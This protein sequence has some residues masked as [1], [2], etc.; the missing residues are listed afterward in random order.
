M[1]TLNDLYKRI[2]SQLKT[3][4][5]SGKSEV[6]VRLNNNGIGPMNTVHISYASLGIDWDSGKFIL[7]PEINLKEEN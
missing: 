4:P 1:L 3:M 2:E 6:V 5:S 7:Y